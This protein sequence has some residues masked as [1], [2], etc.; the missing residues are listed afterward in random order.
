MDSKG[1][2][3]HVQIQ[4]RRW[5]K[6]KYDQANIRKRTVCLSKIYQGVCMMCDMSKKVQGCTGLT[7]CDNKDICSSELIDGK[8]KQ[9][10]V[11]NQSCQKNSL[12]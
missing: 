12:F 9:S 8:N 2:R 1:R 3:A 10:T 7:G 4:P 6:M 11:K 5:K